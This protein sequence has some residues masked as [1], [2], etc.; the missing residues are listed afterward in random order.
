[1]K[2]LTDMIHYITGDLLQSNCQ[3][4]ANT[5]NCVGIMGKGIALQFKQAYPAMHAKYREQCQK[6]QWKPGMVARYMMPNGQQILNV[7]TKDHWSNPS[8]LP[9]IVGALKRIVDNHERLEIT[10]L[11]VPKLGCGN[12][13]LDWSIVGPLMAGSLRKLPF[14]TWIY[15]SPNDTQY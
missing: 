15:I 9:W 8:E 10:S 2:E 4:I 5:V 14:D 12:G 1:M 6:G 3:T 7:A 11:A 13:G